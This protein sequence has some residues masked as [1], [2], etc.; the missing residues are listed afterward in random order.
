M[1]LETFL[2]WIVIGAVAGFLANAIV[3]SGYGLAGDIIIG[4][5]GAFIGGWVFNAMRWH[6]PF[7]GIAGTIVVA[8]V[9]AV[10][11]LVALRLVR[12]AQSRRS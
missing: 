10:L 4:V 1:T 9:G 6:T 7:A 11:L 8:L 12:S 3:R 5:A 2:L